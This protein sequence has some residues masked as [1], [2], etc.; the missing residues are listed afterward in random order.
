MSCAK[1]WF[2]QAIRHI[3][4]AFSPTFSTGLYSGSWNWRIFNFAKVVN[5]PGLVQEVLSK[6]Q[7][8]ITKVLVS[9]FVPGMQVVYLTSHAHR[10]EAPT[11]CGTSWLSDNSIP[12][13]E[14]TPAHDLDCIA[15]RHQA[16]QTHLSDRW[17]SQC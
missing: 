7:V 2:I 4:S 9:P 17:R 5:K 3:A 10:H 15:S 13:L 14:R 11:G 1:I 8:A 12:R 16:L 6:Y